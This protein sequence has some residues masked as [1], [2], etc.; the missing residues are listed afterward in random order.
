MSSTERLSVNLSPEEHRE[1]AAL[2]EKVRVSK[3]W[4]GRRAISE[5]LERYREREF[6][7]PLPPT[8]QGGMPRDQ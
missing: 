5:L 6:Q 8:A 3:A 1:L 2:A 7:L 4:L